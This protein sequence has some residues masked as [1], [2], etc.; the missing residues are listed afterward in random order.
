MY[1]TLMYQTS[2][3]SWTAST[4]WGLGMSSFIRA[5]RT[6]LTECRFCHKYL[7]TSFRISF[8]MHLWETWLLKLNNERITNFVL[9]FLFF[10]LIKVSKGMKFVGGETAALS[11]VY[12]YFWKKVRSYL[13]LTMQ[14]QFM[15]CNCCSKVI[16][17]NENSSSYELYI[18]NL[19]LSSWNEYVT[20]C[21]GQLD[22]MGLQWPRIQNTM[23]PFNFKWYKNWKKGI[24]NK[25]IALEALVRF[26]KH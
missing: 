9:L 20:I 18:L 1:H 19:S 2:R 24:K 10:L 22:M 25:L 21:I 15:L 7:M 26:W 23:E 4:N 13:K 8:W 17:H 6:L 5:A 11:R 14:I 16:F 12:E 3:S